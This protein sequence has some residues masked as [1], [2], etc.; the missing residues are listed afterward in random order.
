[1]T[2]PFR[3]HCEGGNTYERAQAQGLHDA[4]CLQ[5]TGLKVMQIQD[6]LGTP[7]QE[8]HVGPPHIVPC[9]ADVEAA[10]FKVSQYA[11]P[12]VAEPSL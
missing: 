2:R 1:M 8:R 5:R 10:L 7:D 6:D 9:H 4:A 12:P 3:I 11:M